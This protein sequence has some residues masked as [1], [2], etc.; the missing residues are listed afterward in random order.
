M[1]T[2]ALVDT[3]PRP[4]RV[5][6]R[7]DGF[8]V[9]G[10]QA[11]RIDAN[12]IDMVPVG[13]LTNVHGVAQPVGHPLV[14]LSATEDAVAVDA[15]TDPLPTIAVRAKPRRFVHLLPKAVLPRLSQ[16]GSR[17]RLPLALVVDSAHPVGVDATSAIGD[18]AGVS[19]GVAGAEPL[20]VA[21]PAHI[22][23]NCRDVPVRLAVAKDLGSPSSRAVF[24]GP[25][26]T[27]Q[28][29]VARAQPIP[30]NTGETVGDG[31]IG[32]RLWHAFIVT[33]ERNKAN[34]SHSLLVR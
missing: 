9:R 5:F 31:A 2:L 26:T 24:G 6:T 15:R 3:N 10:I 28:H 13:D 29:V 18:G 11:R 17:A 7:V 8:K 27:V 12:V 20:R 21:R 19:F 25:V 1:S 23:N 32:D 14:P 16:K 34:G 22:A 33:K 30:P 4:L